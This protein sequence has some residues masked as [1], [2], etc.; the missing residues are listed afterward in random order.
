MQLKS[1]R[2][3]L[4]QFMDDDIENMFKGLSNPKVI[5]HYGIS[6]KSLEVT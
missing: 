2:L 5:Q 6:F 4:R 1:K 3:L